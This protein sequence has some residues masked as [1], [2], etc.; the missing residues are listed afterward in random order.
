MRRRARLEA[1]SANADIACT[2]PA[3]GDSCARLL[4]ALVNEMRRVSAASVDSQF[5]LPAPYVH[6]L[7]RATRVA[8]L[9]AS[10]VASPRFA[11]G[12]C[13]ALRRPIPT[14]RAGP[15]AGWL[16]PLGELRARQRRI[17]REIALH[18]VRNR[19]GEFLLVPVA[20]EFQLFV[21]I[22]NECRLDQYR[23]NVGSF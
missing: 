6:R 4:N 22:G 18:A 9:S 19:F 15:L 12:P 2:M 23:G 10:G 21:W 1:A 16:A 14:L 8:G 7:L 13:S 5:P 3:S 17:L 20:F 11:R